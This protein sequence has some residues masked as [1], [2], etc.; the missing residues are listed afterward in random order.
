MKRVLLLAVCLFSLQ[1]NATISA[2]A[3]VTTTE[4]TA[5]IK[6]LLQ[7]EEF[8]ETCV[9][10]SKCGELSDVVL[11]LAQKKKVYGNALVLGSLAVVTLLGIFL[12][13]NPALVINL[14]ESTGSLCSWFLDDAT[15]EV[16]QHCSDIVTQV[17]N[18]AD[19]CYDYFNE[20][21]F[22]YGPTKLVE[23]AQDGM[24]EPVSNLTICPANPFAQV[25]DV[26]RQVSGTWLPDRDCFAQ[27]CPESMNIATCVATLENSYSQ[28]EYL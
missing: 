8:V 6:D 9:Q 17:C 16:A 2:M 12:C 10:L 22:E 14:Y 26:C 25:I 19:T 13:C 4:L 15:T 20:C 28:Y 3:T 7:D 27:F 18:S 1:V 24:R 23:I 5:M 21:A 11:G